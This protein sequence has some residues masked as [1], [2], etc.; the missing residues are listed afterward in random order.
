MARHVKHLENGLKFMPVP[1]MGVNFSFL[2]LKRR[3]LCGHRP[4]F[5][6]STK[7]LGPFLSKAWVHGVLRWRA[8]VDV[9]GT[10]HPKHHE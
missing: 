5:G 4:E 3:F 6:Q 7:S 2:F 1:C 8:N 9:E 10:Y